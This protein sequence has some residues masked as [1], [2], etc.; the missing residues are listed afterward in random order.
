MVH[1][2]MHWCLSGDEEETRIRGVWSTRVAAEEQ[3]KQIKGY[4]ANNEWW[5]EEWVVDGAEGEP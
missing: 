5:I 1:V 4:P 2:V 3:L